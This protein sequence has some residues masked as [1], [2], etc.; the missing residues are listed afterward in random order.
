LERPSWIEG[1]SKEEAECW[2][3]KRKRRIIARRK[4]CGVRRE[5]RRFRTR[6]KK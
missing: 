5:K 3:K 4:K 2:S 6:R 1:G